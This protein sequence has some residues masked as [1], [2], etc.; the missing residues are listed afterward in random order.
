MKTGMITAIAAVAALLAGAGVAQDQ[1]P[2]DPSQ[3]AAPPAG[4]GHDGPPL[5]YP[6]PTPLRRGQF[7][8]QGHAQ[9]IIPAPRFHF[10]R[11][12]QYRRWSAGQ[13]L[14][15]LFLRAPYVFTNFADYGFGPPPFGDQWVRYGP[16]LLLVDARSGRV[17][18]VV[19]GA[20]D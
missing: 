8:Y 15:K 3:G 10:P 20:F 16:D 2:V 12:Y 11:G 18:D 6:T 5:T 14:P 17:V 19:Y 9:R 4:P 7:L 13:M 1:R